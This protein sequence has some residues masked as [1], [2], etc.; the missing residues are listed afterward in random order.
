M[1]RIKQENKQSRQENCSL[2]HWK[3]NRRKKVEDKSQKKR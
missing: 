1:K 2:Y 3:Q